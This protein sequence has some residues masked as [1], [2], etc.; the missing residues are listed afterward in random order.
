MTLASTAPMIFA[1]TATASA[2]PEPWVVH[3]DRNT[4]RSTRRAAEYRTSVYPETWI[5]A[6]QPRPEFDR[7]R[8][9]QA[10][11]ILVAAH[12]EQRIG[13]ENFESWLSDILAGIEDPADQIHKWQSPGHIAHARQ[14]LSRLDR[15]MREG[16]TDRHPLRPHRREHPL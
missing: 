2:D 5:W 12:E 1:S 11:P 7:P 3:G 13:R 4:F 15:H 6:Y 8:K 10:N 9:H 14:V 16:E